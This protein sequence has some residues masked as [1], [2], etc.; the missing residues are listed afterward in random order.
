MAE[1]FYGTIPRGA[2]IT[3]Q[4]PTEPPAHADRRVIKE[5]ARV[6]QASLQRG[7]L[8]PSYNTAKDA[9]APYA[10]QILES[11]MGGSAT[12]RLYKSLVIDQKIAI[13]AGVSYSPSM[14]DMS[15][16]TFYVSPK[17]GIKIDDVEAALLKE[18]NILIEK[19]VTQDEVRRAQKT[20]VNEAVFARD[21]SGTAA[22]VLGSSLAI[23]LTTDSIENW[24][25]AISNITSEDINR[26]LRDVL[27]N[28]KTVTGLL[29]GKGEKS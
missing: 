13:S 3:R 22:Q 6:R 17:P 5:D 28:Q 19:G 16:L 26:A 24:P 25:N 18:I 27:V 7:Y 20:L 12:S 4:R 1:K 21:N 15:E 10:L 14:L 9:K 23:G 29:L 8:A 2:D 11:I